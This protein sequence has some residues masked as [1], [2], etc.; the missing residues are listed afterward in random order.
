MDE[1][2]GFAGFG[3]PNGRWRFQDREVEGGGVGRCGSEEDLG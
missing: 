3:E 1:R 2:E